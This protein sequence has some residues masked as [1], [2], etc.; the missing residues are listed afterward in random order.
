M[1][2]EGK[3][4]IMRTFHVIPCREH[5]VSTI[6]I[7]MLKPQFKYLGTTVTN[8]KL[9][10]EEIKGRLNSGNACYHSV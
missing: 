10:Q 1:T 6:T 2:D 7:K 4:A 8:Q 5:S 9:I 3:S